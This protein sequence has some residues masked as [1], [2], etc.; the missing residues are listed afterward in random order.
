M[1]SAFSA[2]TAVLSLGSALTWAECERSEAPGIPD[3]S[4][5]SEQEMIDSQQNLKQYMAA[6]ETYLGCIDKEEQARIEVEAKA[7]EPASEE[8]RVERATAHTSTYNEVVQEMETNAAEFNAQLK[9]YREA[10]GEA[11]GAAQ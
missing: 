8:A 7:S 5:A 4:K 3:G 10:Q 2:A 11:Q 6:T 9:V 1:R